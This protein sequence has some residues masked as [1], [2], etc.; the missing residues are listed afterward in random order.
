MKSVSSVVEELIK[1]KPYIEEALSQDLI[2]ISSL[3]R[4]LQG[5]IE[6]TLKKEVREGAI[7]MAIK[8]I[9]PVLQFELENKIQQ[10]IKLL[11]DITVRSNLVKY[12]FKNSP[13]MTVRQ[14]RLLDHMGDEGKDIFYTFSQGVYE[15][16]III[17][18]VVENKVDNY[19]MSESLISKNTNLASI[20]VR[21]PAENSGCSGL[22]YYIFKK[23]AW[24]GINLLEVVSTT[25][26]FTLIVTQEDVDKAFSVIKKLNKA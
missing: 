4:V 16:T 20:T 7:I 17:S 15:T 14:S 18:N 8:R 11:G 22:Y 1:Q 9:H 3:A 25:N 24:E 5:E 13:T 12:T 6:A 23:V 26:E 19:F 21:L 2:N 10:T